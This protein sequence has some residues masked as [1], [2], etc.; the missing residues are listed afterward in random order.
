MRD[1][2]FFPLGTLA[3]L[4]VS[5]AIAIEVLA[6]DHHMTFMQVVHILIYR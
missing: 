4:V 5:T 1:A 6:I 2:I 3:S